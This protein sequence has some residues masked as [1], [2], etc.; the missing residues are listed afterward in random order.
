MASGD[1]PPVRRAGGDRRIESRG[2]AG[3]ISR[4]SRRVS[5]NEKRGGPPRG[6]DVILDR[7]RAAPRG[8]ESGS[9]CRAA[10]APLG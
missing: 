5:R 2:L 8:S 7:G 1:R 3:L 9:P 10:P 4:I 6:R